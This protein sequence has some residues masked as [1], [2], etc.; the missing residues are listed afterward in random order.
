MWVFLGWFVVLTL[1]VRKRAG[2]NNRDNEWTFGQ[3][4]ALATW[5]P[6]ITEF[7]YI[8]WEDPEKAMSGRLMEP[9]E[10][11]ANH[12]AKPAKTMEMEPLPAEGESDDLQRLLE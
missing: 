5:V 12:T 8:W 11:I 6:F 7:A 10:V 2:E 4:L 9:Y 3:V 1:Q